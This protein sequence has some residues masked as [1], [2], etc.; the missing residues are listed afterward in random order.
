MGPDLQKLGYIS[1]HPWLRFFV[2]K[3]HIEDDCEA[4]DPWNTSKP[5][6]SENIWPRDDAGNVISSRIGVSSLMMMLEKGLLRPELIKIRDYHI[7][8]ANFMLC[9]EKTRIRDYRIGY[10]KPESEFE[11][12][13]ALARDLIDGLDIAIISVDMRN[14]ELKPSDDSIFKSGKVNTE[15]ILVDPPRITEVSICVSPEHQGQGVGLPMLHSALLRTDPY[16]IDLVLGFASRLD[17]LEIWGSRPVDRFLIT[18]S[19]S[20]KLKRLCTYHLILNQ[21]TVLALLANSKDT[22]TTLHLGMVVFTDHD[23]WKDLLSIV[24]RDYPQLT[25]FRLGV[26]RQVGPLSHAVDVFGFN[27]DQVPEQCRPGLDMPLK[28]PLE[29]KRLTQIKYQGPDAGSVLTKLAKFAD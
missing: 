17:N 12:V 5:L 29:N 28:G 2:K 11:A 25:E 7:E 13:S 1:Q 20:V 4:N 16:W 6:Q 3:I 23:S 24:G 10:G 14:G 8:Q 26:L 18:K 22:L 27:K 15:G 9:P 21:R 19:Q